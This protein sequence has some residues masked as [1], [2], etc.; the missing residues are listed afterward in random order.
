M[1]SGI[2]TGSTANSVIAAKIEW[3]SVPN[4]VT[5]SSTVTARLYLRRTNTYTG[6][7]TGGANYFKLQIGEA[8]FENSGE[9]LSIPND[10]SW[11]LACQ[12]TAVILHG[13]DGRKT[14]SIK[15][16]GSLP[17]SSVAWVSCQA[18][19]VLDHILSGSQILSFTGSWEEL[20]GV[21]SPVADHHRLRLL[22][23][24]EALR[25]V[26]LDNL[27]A[28]PEYTFCLTPEEREKLY[29]AQTPKVTLTLAL[30]TYKDA[31]CTQQQGSTATAALA[32]DMPAEVSPQLQVQVTP[33]WPEGTAEAVS[34]CYVQNNAGMQVTVTATAKYGAEVVSTKLAVNGSPVEMTDGV[35]ASGVLTEAGWVTV[36]A[37]ATD[38]RDLTATAE[39]KIYIH[40]Y[41]EPKLT[42]RTCSRC[43]E[44]GTLTDEGTCLYVD[45]AAE[46]S[47]IPAEGGDINTGALLVAIKP[48]G[49]SQYGEPMQLPADQIVA[50][51]GS[52]GLKVHWSYHAQIIARDG[53]GKAAVTTFL[54]PTAVVQSHEG[55]G[56][57][58]LGKYSDG[59]GLDIADQWPVR[60]HSENIYI[61]VGNENEK[62]PV[63]LADYIRKI[64]NGG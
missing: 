60:I 54:I 50:Y 62:Q 9:R 19:A 18:D 56:F 11:A 33:L 47:P 10:N 55:D 32:L 37:T 58:A 26:T 31:Q 8:T 13:S 48:A 36:A 39:Q 6:T 34:A 51:D 52:N 29:A 41:T 64:I 46:Y 16:S 4:A 40:P 38:S 2:I 45:A 44:N 22:Y 57:L 5:C 25:T 61:Y 3:E 49:Q 35:Y 28:T 15:A 14:V 23:G 59:R 43:D 42:V 12:G 21:F 17:P 27:R 30:D 7:A 24:Q 1:T 53:V 63:S 20:K